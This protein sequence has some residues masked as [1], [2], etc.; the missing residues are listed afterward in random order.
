MIVF[1]MP[2]ASH[3]AWNLLGLWLCL[4]A[5]ILPVTVHGQVSAVESVRRLKPASGLEAT[6]WASE[7]MVVNPTNMDIDSRGQGLGH[8][9]AEL[10]THPRRKPAFHRVEDADKI[11]ILEDTDGDGKADK[12]TVFAD[13]I[14]PVPMG[15]AVEE[16]YGKDGKYHGLQGLRRQQP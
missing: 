12:M 5:W 9:G 6:L 16:N 3:A 7:P 1:T 13:Q 4:T 14:F 11:K 10:P 15:I 8:R 2:R